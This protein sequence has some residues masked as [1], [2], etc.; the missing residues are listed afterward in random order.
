[1]SETFWP[2][3]YP[4]PASRGVQTGSAYS[5]MSVI[6]WIAIGIAV[7]VVAL[8]LHDLFQRRHALLRAYPLVGRARYMLERIGPELRQYW[9]TPDKLE[10]P[11]DRTQRDWIY[12]SAKRE[13]NT[14]GFGTESE[15]ETSPN[16][17]VIRHAPFPHPAPKKGHP[18]GPPRFEMP[19]AKVLGAARDRPSA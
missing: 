7:V 9:F 18:G 12:E 8:A 4:L 16:Y 1:M 19:C 13:T 5:G 10:R 2:I 14:F 3:R 15:L 11:F 17:L 6:A